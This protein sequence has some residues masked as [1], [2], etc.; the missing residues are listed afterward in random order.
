MTRDEMQVK[1]LG[2]LAKGN[3]IHALAA[4]DLFHETTRIAHSS[5]PVRGFRL[6]EIQGS[7]AV[8]Q[9][10]EQQPA[11]Q[12]RWVGVMAQHPELRSP[13]LITLSSCRVGMQLTDGAVFHGTG[14]QRRTAPRPL[15]IKPKSMINPINTTNNPLKDD[16]PPNDATAQQ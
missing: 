12:R 5:A 7:G 9:C 6:R 4:G 14:V 3:G 16:T 13:N 11:W 10:V 1:V 15:P 8:T 2:P